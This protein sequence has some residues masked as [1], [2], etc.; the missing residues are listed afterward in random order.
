MLHT[1]PFS[2]EKALIEQARRRSEAVQA[3]PVTLG[4]GAIQLG[5]ARQSL[6]IPQDV[7]YRGG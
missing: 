6:L 7:L 1:I 4:E 2:A 5:V 3:A